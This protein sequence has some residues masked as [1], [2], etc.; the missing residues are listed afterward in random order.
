MIVNEINLSN[1]IPKCTKLG[2]FNVLNG[3][4]KIGKNVVLG[5]N[6]VISGNIEI[7]DNCIIG[8]SVEITG[9]VKIGKSCTLSSGVKF[10]GAAQHLKVSE[11]TDKK[12]IIGSHNTFRE[13]S[14]IHMPYHKQVTIVGN[15]NYIMVNVNIPHDA[16]VGNNNVICNNVS[17]GGSVE[18]GNYCNLG[19]NAVL[20][21]NIKVG[22][23]AMI[24]MGTI[25]DKNILPFS[26]VSG[27]KKVSLSINIVGFNRN[28]TGDIRMKDILS[29]LKAPFE[30]TPFLT[31]LKE[32]K[33]FLEYDNS[34]GFYLL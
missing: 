21:Q 34:K 27:S 14:T 8:N 33:D 9:D 32:T 29:M 19:L 10:G 5:S 25:I 3:N 28:Y 7:G 30:S 16:K 13:N 4:V 24:G 1:L 15:N 11:L 23:Y 2:S 22:S 20:H 31:Q 18:L 17:L 26:M 12:I 6:C